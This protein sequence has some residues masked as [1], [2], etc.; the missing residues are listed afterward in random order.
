MSARAVR[1]LVLF[2]GALG[3]LLC[4]WPALDGLIAAGHAVT[5][6]ARTDAAEVLPADGLRRCSIERREIVELFASDPLTDAARGFFGGFDRIDSFTGAGQAAFAER[7][8]AAAGRPVS[9]HPFRGMRPDEHA[10]VYFAR[11]LGIAPRLRVL[12]VRD[13]AAAWT[14]ALW[15]RQRLGDRVLALHP[16]SGGAAKN[17]DGMAEVVHAWRH[18]GGRVLALLGPAEIERRTSVPADVVVAGEPLAR[19]AAVV[20]RAHR[21]LGN[22]SGISHLAGLVGA[23]ALVLFGDTDPA[24]WAPRGDHVRVLR[25]EAPCGACGPGRFCTHRLSVAAVV[26]ALA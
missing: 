8:A 14:A 19:V 16:G 5:L 23:A 2:P 1:T 9:V 10:T 26:A 3:D 12:P 4:C 18:G 11:C 15:N 13:D 21:F 25:G 6:A 17:W 24:V 22:D 7:L 20:R